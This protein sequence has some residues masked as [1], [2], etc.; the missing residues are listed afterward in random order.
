M[1]CQIGSIKLNKWALKL[2]FRKSKK[3][4]PRDLSIERKSWHDNTKPL[5]D[6]LDFTLSDFVDQK[7]AGDTSK[8]KANNA[9]CWTINFFF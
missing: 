3:I 6:R 7:I 4:L 5:V 1:S 8:I 2:K 9:M